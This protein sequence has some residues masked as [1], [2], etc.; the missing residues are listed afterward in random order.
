MRL[1]TRTR[2][3]MT[4]KTTMGLRPGDHCLLECENGM[5]MA[6]AFLGPVANSRT[7]F[8]GGLLAPAFRSE[9]AI[10]PAR[11]DIAPAAMVH[12]KCY[13]ENKTPI[14]GNLVH[15]VG[16]N[17]VDLALSAGTDTSVGAVHRVLGYLALLERAR[18]IAAAVWA[19][20]SPM[21]A[22]RRSIHRV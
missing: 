5:S 4:P 3:G 20:P 9:E 10:L 19:C 14:V 21:A 13:A 15:A 22:F 11:L 2:G 18:M 1:P 16:S 17:A 6:F 7:A 12:V 8:Y